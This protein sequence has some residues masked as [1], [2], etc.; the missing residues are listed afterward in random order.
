MVNEIICEPFPIKLELNSI[1]ELERY[2][3]LTRIFNITFNIFKFIKLVQ[4]DLVFPEVLVYWMVYSQLKYFREIYLYLYFQ[5]RNY[6]KFDFNC[7][8]YCLFEHKNINKDFKFM[9]NDLDIFLDISSSLVRSRGRLQNSILS[10]DA[11]HPILMSS[12]CHL[13]KLIVSKTHKYNM[14]GGVQDT[15]AAVRRQ[16]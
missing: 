13:T 6:C 12:K 8:N 14:H 4:P 10:F 1:F 11:K 9:I 3:N 16:I 5:V 7:F 15:L 2:S